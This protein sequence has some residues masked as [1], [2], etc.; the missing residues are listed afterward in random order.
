LGHDRVDWGRLNE[1]KALA[2]EQLN[3]FGEFR[4]KRRKR[5]PA[6]EMD[7]DA[8][9]RW[10]GRIFNYQQGVRGSQASRQ[11]TLF[12]LPKT[13]DPDQIDP[14]NLK[15]ETI[16]FWTMPAEAFGY[17]CF[18]FVIDNSL[19]ILLYVGETSKNNQRWKGTHDC[20]SYI[21]KYDSLHYKHGLARAVCIAF[22]FDAPSDRNQGL[23]A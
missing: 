10:K 23:W 20:K 1:E 22:S 6:L 5:T 17:P 19:P 3:L 7:A 8:L 14:F 13:I 15:L 4:P 18:Y 9:M 21:G 2:H 11:T 16:H 12:E